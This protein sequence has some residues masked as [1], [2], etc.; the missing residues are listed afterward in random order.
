[1]ANRPD[2]MV[3]FSS[4]GPTVERRFKSEVV[5][6][7]TSILSAKPRNAPVDTIYR[8]STDPNWMFDSG[9]SMSTPLVAGY[10]AVLWQTFVTNGISKPSAT[11]IKALL[12]NGADELAGQYIVHT[13]RGG[14]VA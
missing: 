9:T 8:A 4:C 10:A 13:E 1:M 5:A 7:A 3:A 11:R 12:I 2:G 6:P 14:C